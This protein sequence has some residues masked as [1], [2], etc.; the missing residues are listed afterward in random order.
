MGLEKTENLIAIMRVAGKDPS[1]RLSYHAPHQGQ[2]L[3]DLCPG[4][5][6]HMVPALSY[7]HPRAARDL[8]HYPLRIA[9][10][11]AHQTQQP[12]IPGLKPRTCMLEIATARRA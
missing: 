6:D 7:R 2:H 10:R 12:T 3:F 8:A 5:L 1:P 9:H 11:R 4:A